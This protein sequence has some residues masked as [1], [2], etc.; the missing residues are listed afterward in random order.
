MHILCFNSPGFE[1]HF[2]S[3]WNN[4]ELARLIQTDTIVVGASYSTDEV[5]IDAVYLKSGSIVYLIERLTS[6]R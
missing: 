6:S 5:S 1:A 2:R 3:W 4:G